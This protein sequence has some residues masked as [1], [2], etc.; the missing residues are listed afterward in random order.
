MFPTLTSWL[1]RALLSWAQ[2]SH[3]HCTTCWD[4]CWQWLGGVFRFVGFRGSKTPID[5]S[6]P[7]MN[8]LLWTREKTW[9]EAST[10]RI[11]KI[12]YYPSQFSSRLS[13]SVKKWEKLFFHYRYNDRYSLF[14]KSHT[15][16]MSEE[17]PANLTQ[18][19]HLVQWFKPGTFL[20]WDNRA[21]GAF[22][23]YTELEFTSSEWEI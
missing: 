3:D 21:V 20:L 22:L 12:S 10:K 16:C 9:S 7:G 8:L 18:P 19:T 5:D 6:L 13:L 11:N 1:H 14:S 2:L 4:F 23:F 15:I 17:N